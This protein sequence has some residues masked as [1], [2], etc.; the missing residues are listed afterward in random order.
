MNSL[1]SISRLAPDSSFQLLIRE[2]D[3]LTFLNLET[4]GRLPAVNQFFFGNAIN[5]FLYPAAVF[6]VEQIEVDRRRWPL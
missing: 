5:F 6:G 2:R 1:I 4:V 3:V